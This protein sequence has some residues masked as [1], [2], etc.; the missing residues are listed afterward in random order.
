VADGLVPSSQTRCKKAAGRSGHAPVASVVRL[1]AHGDALLV[2]AE[3]DVLHPVEARVALDHTRGAVRLP[4]LALH[5]RLAVLHEDGAVGI[6]LGHLLLPLLQPGHH[7]CRHV[8]QAAQGQLWIAAL[9]AIANTS[10]PPPRG[11]VLATHG[12]TAPPA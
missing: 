8:K 1:A 7:V 2:F 3:D 4:D 9:H 10:W 5:V 12:A 11:S 6:A